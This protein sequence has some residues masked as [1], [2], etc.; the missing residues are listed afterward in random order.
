M[1]KD[2]DTL[3][4]TY[5]YSDGTSCNRPLTRG[6]KDKEGEQYCIFHT[7]D[8]EKLQ[9]LKQEMQNEISTAANLFKK[10]IKTQNL[11]EDNEDQKDKIAELRSK[12]ALNYEGTYFPDSFDLFNYFALEVGI[13][14]NKAVFSGV[15]YFREAT[16]SGEAHFWEATFNGGADFDGATFSSEARFWQATFSREAYFSG[17]T[18]SGKADF[19]EATFNGEVHFPRATF[20][21][22]ADFQEVTFG[23]KVNFQFA[24]F[25]ENAIFYKAT[26]SGG[27]GFDGAAFSG[28]AYFSGATFSGSADFSGATFSGEVEFTDV[29]FI[30]DV[31]FDKCRPD[32]GKLK[33]LGTT[34]FSTGS[35]HDISEGSSITFINCC[36]PGVSFLRSRI[37]DTVFSNCCFNLTEGW[38]NKKIQKINEE[39][40]SGGV[41]QFDKERL[42]QRSILLT[43]EKDKIDGLKG[44]NKRLQKKNLLLEHRDFFNRPNFRI[45]MSKL[46]IRGLKIASAP[47]LHLF[48]HKFNS[49][50]RKVKSLKETANLIDFGEVK[51]NYMQLKVNMDRMKDYA[52][53][54]DFYNGEMEMK[55]LGE[56]L[57][58]PKRWF[59]ALYKFLSGYGNRPGQAVGVFV[60]LMA[61]FSL[62]LFFDLVKIRKDIN[63]GSMLPQTER[64]IEKDS[65]Y[66]VLMNPLFIISPDLK[67]NYEKK[68]LQ[69]VLNIDD[70]PDRNVLDFLSICSFNITAISNI[71]KPTYIASNEWS[72]YYLGFVHYFIRPVQIALII[73]AIRR[74]VKRG[75]E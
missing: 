16:F 53:A 55:R 20:S 68:A 47:L 39:L 8:D 7:R 59:L 56:K 13:S 60:L 70:V 40:K 48:P 52:L 19:S 32:K 33:F 54:N 38:I 66:S 69:N 57:Y 15:V 10:E 11:S 14:F 34:F 73:L 49:L 24:T 51:D 37:G 50:R 27:A 75:E 5:K 72:S 2:S 31:F 12:Y 25:S 21:G 1:K 26:F 42:N 4:C 9:E 3:T 63:Y 30:A 61:L 41:A 36:L 58:K 74:K 67:A 29:L 18:F 22:E 23:G 44:R 62:P 6:F 71:Y 35:F 64:K 17:A 65:F 28:K 46:L 45:L 43:Q